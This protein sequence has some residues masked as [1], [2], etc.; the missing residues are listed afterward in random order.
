MTEL[1]PG[2]EVF[3]A[4]TGWPS[5]GVDHGKASA[6]LLNQAT[7]V[8]NA[9]KFLESKK[10]RYNIIEAFDQPWKIFG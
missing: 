5:N 6:T 10:I 8:R 3:I 2:K 4:E 9:S 1:F 7:Y